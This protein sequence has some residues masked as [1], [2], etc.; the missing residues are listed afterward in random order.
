MLPQGAWAVAISPPLPFLKVW[1]VGPMA[2]S[3]TA[4][5]KYAL[6]SLDGRLIPGSNETIGTSFAG[7]SC[8]AF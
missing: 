8:E 7:E 5:V 2:V 3:G 6:Y 1:N 4:L